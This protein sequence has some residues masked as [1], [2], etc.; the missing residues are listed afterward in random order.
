MATDDN[1]PQQSFHALHRELWDRLVDLALAQIANRQIRPV[2]RDAQKRHERVA[3]DMR[4]SLEYRFSAI[5][6][7]AGILRAYQQRALQDLA[8]T[9][10]DGNQDSYDIVYTARRQQQML[11][12]SVIFN[13]LALFDYIGNAVG[14]SFYGHTSGGT[15]WKWKRAVQYAANADAEQA[16][17]GSRRYSQSAVA[18]C[19]ASVDK[20]WIRRLEEYRAELI[21]YK[22]EPAGGN[23]TVSFKQGGP[24]TVTLTVTTP[25]A[26]TKW[27]NMPGKKSK[28]GVF[29]LEAADWLIL[30]TQASACQIVDVLVQELERDPAPPDGGLRVART[31]RPPST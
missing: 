10:T 11:F 12:D 14:F 30:Q 31:R 9:L 18:R 8:N 27:V 16:K 20:S 29:V 15:K 23:N 2:D 24:V 13:V 6:L 22:T 28:E 26:F 5:G 1:A 19:V 7:H 25:P 3:L 17:H 21:H 4:E